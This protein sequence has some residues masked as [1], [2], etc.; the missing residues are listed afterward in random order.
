MGEAN[1]PIF[2]RARANLPDCCG[3]VTGISEAFSRHSR[4]F[5]PRG[6]AVSFSTMPRGAALGFHARPAT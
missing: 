3:T 1:P 6:L 2:A 4:K 5:R